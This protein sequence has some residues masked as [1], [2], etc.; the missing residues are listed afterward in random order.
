[1]HNSCGVTALICA[2][3]NGRTDIVNILASRNDTRFEQKDQRGETALSIAKKKGHNEIV[4]CLNE[5]KQLREVKGT[6][7]QEDSLGDPNGILSLILSQHEIDTK[8]LPNYRNRALLHVAKKGCTD[9][10]HLL[11]ESKDIKLG[12]EGIDTNAA[13]ILAAREGH[14]N[15]V[16]M[17]LRRINADPSFE[18]ENGES[19]I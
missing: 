7:L 5:Y 16:H 4:R 19:A 17:L 15:T 1:M 12:M 3:G 9:I 14:E 18:N 13:L 10:L 8:M 11:L 2:T 6:K